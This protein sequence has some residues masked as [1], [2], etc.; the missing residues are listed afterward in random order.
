MTASLIGH[1][2][3]APLIQT[4]LF[5]SE[6][7]LVNEPLDEPAHRSGGLADGD[8]RASARGVADPP[9]GPW[10]PI[11]QQRFQDELAKRG[12]DCSTSSAENCYDNAAVESFSG[13]CKRECVNR[14]F[15]NHPLKPSRITYRIPDLPQYL[16]NDRIWP[17]AD[18]SGFRLKDCVR[19]HI[20]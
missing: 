12:T 14:I 1:V 6:C 19:I 16:L 18:I 11:Y 20:H 17:R 3:Q 4:Y 9:L 5:S 13:L 15:L 10:W 7:G 2:S 8:R